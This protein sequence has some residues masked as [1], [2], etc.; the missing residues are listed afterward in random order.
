LKGKS[1]TPACALKSSAFWGKKSSSF[2][3]GAVAKG[4]EYGG[5]KIRESIK[6]AS[7]PTGSANSDG[8]ATKEK[9]R[10]KLRKEGEEK[11]D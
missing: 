4:R 2:R 10:K 8:K 11:G 9:R 6:K 5:G 1:Q 7:P 3:R